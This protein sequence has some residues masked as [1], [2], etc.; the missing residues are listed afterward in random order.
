MS[1]DHEFRPAADHQLPN[2]SS[3]QRR[4][5]DVQ[6]RRQ[7]SVATACS[8]SG[9]I[10]NDHHQILLENK[11]EEED[12]ECCR[13]P[14]SKENKIP[15]MVS[16]PPAPR[17]KRPPVVSCKRKLSDDQLQLF[18]FISHEQVAVE[19]SRLFELSN[20]VLLL[21]KRRRSDFHA[22]QPSDESN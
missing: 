16:C 15:V 3:I 1:T 2:M 10:N 22:C 5:I 4:P 11:D 17:K 14:K 21:K 6:V 7:S 8:C 12:D 20:S 9:E 19:D 18:E 13:T